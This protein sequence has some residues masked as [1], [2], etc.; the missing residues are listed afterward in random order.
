MASVVILAAACGTI[1]AVLVARAG[2]TLSHY[3]ARGHL[4]VARRIVDSLTPGWQQAGAVWL[5]LPHLLNAIPAQID[6]LYQTGAAAVVVSVASF[7]LAAGAIAWIVSRIAETLWPAAAAAFVF[8]VN[9]N[10]LYLQSTPMTEPLMLGLTLAAVAMLVEWC[11]VADSDNERAGLKART[12]TTGGSADLQ[13]RLESL[14]SAGSA[15]CSRSPVSPVM[16]PGR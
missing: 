11:V 2:L 7:A 6:L 3:D 4:V 8:V 9:P 12:T 1:A 13:V 16:R 10:L 5:P 15:S 14:R